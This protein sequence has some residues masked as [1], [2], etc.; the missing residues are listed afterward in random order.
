MN[1]LKLLWARLQVTISIP[2]AL[3]QYT[4]DK[5]DV[6]L[7]ASTVDELLLKLDGLFPGLRAFI[8]DEGKSVR[9]YVNIFVNEHDIRSGEGLTTKLKDGDRIHI[10]PAV[11]GG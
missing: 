4:Q 5:S 7:D 1:Y 8:V 6:G 10:I 3:R 2:H 11:A 9:R